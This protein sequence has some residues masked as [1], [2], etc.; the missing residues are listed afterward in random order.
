ME[1]LAPFVADKG[2]KKRLWQTKLLFFFLIL[3]SYAK[4]GYNWFQIQ[5]QLQHK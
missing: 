1:N 3:K 2:N 5:A 4:V